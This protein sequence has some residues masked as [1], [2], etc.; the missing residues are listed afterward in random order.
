[1]TFN[2]DKLKQIIN[3]RLCS[4]PKCQRFFTHYTLYPKREQPLTQ[5]KKLSTTLLLLLLFLTLSSHELLLKSD[6]YF[7]N[8]YSQSELYLFNGTFDESENIITR[9]RI[10]EAQI[11]G[12]G[13]TFAPTADDYY[14][15]DEATYLKFK[16]GGAGTYVAG[17]STKPRVIKLSGEK[18]TSY[19]EHEGLS[20]IMAERKRKGITN[21]SAQEKYSKHVKTLLQVGKKKT[22]HYALELD[23][24][25]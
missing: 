22:D 14:D 5:M 19:L 6:S 21:A 12:P 25:I 16:T 7:L 8:K 18:F 24:P 17:I 1:M 20:K 10:I 3:V 15:K 4:S 13:Y 11:N 23:Y 2:V 9:D